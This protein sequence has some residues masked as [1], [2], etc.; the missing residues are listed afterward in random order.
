[1]VTQNRD[2]TEQDR[3]ITVI[4]DHELEGLMPGFVDDWNKDVRTMREALQRAD[5]PAIRKVGHDM[6][7]TGRSCGFDLLTEIGGNLEEAAKRRDPGEIRKD[8]DALSAYL[9]QAEVLCENLPRRSS[10]ASV[11]D[12]IKE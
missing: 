1:M 2:K 3:S 4:V 7:G 8:L 5:Y 12:T 10:P 6:K 9:A 11:E